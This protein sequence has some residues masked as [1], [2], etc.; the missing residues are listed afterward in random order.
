VPFV[1]PAALGAVP[2]PPGALGHPDGPLAAAATYLG[3]SRDQLLGQV[4]SGKS[5]AQVAKAHGK[6]VSGL[7]A[8]VTASLKARLDRAVSAKLITRTQEQEILSRVSSKLDD[9]INRTP[10]SFAFHRGG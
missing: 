2:A 10:P 6:S 9:L 4:A 1:P 3:I 5:L 8:A 7:K